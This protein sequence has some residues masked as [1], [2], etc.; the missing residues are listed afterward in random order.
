MVDGGKNTSKKKRSEDQA[1]LPDDIAKLIINRCS[2]SER[3][4]MGSLCKSWRQLYL[5]VDNTVEFLPWVL[6]YNWHKR[7]IKLFDPAAQTTYTIKPSHHINLSRTVTCESKK[8]WILLSKSVC[9]GILF[10]FYSPF[11]NEFIK[12]PK[13]KTSDDKC[14]I[15][16][17]FSS[18]PTCVDCTVF[19]MIRENRKPLLHQIKLLALSDKIWKTGISG[20]FY[21]LLQIVHS[22]DSFLLSLSLN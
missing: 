21:D 6:S 2:E 15:I 12:L 10:Y 3:V 16:A 20:D 17:T 11:T 8:C 14:Q 13:L 19:V 18:N 5:R 4:L 22:D 9:C 7:I 1:D